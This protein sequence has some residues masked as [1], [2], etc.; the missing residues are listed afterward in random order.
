MATLFQYGQ[1]K[2]TQQSQKE[3]EVMECRREKD[4]AIAAAKV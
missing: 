2:E 1:T 3:L 4:T